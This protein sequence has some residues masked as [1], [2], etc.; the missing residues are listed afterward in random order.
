MRGRPK[1]DTIRDRVIRIRLTS[2]EYDQLRQFT[3][4][5]ETSVSE[6]IRNIVKNYMRDTTYI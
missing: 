2:D 4:Q 3:E 5:N 1:K 6:L